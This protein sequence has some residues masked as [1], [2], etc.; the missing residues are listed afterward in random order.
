MME[1]KMM[2]QTPF[3]SKNTRVFCLEELCVGVSERGVTL[4]GIFN[5]LPT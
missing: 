5:R 3:N 4:V 1:E 2:I